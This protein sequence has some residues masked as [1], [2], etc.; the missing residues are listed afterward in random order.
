MRWSKSDGK[1]PYRDLF[2]RPTPGGVGALL[3]GVVERPQAWGKDPHRNL[4][5]LCYCVVMNLLIVLL[6]LLLLF[7]GGGFYLGGPA[8]GGGGIGL[9]LVIC[10]IVYC[11]GGFRRTKT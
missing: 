8:I 4:A 11:M 6:L 2:L 5:V 7:G 3:H 1:F 9:I 10:L